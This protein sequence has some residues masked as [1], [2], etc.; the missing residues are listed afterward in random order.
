VSTE[1]EGAIHLEGHERR[2]R[3]GTV[4]KEPGGRNKSLLDGNWAVHLLLFQQPL[5]P[6]DKL[7]SQGA[8][9]GAGSQ[10]LCELG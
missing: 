4:P 10:Q 8:G 3:E 9:F 5:W 1:G 2:G 7:I 6:S